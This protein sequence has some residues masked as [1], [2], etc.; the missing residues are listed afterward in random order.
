MTELGSADDQKE[1]DLE[2][3]GV[4][5]FVFGVLY[6]CRVWFQACGY[7]GCQFSALVG[8]DHEIA[9]DL[10]SSSGDRS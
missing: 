6:S 1:L 2:S 7:A 10:D 9:C 5:I 8:A 3:L 4:D